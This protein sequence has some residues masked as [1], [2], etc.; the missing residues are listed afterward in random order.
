[1]EWMQQFTEWLKPYDEYTHWYVAVVFFVAGVFTVANA[2][3]NTWKE[4]NKIRRASYLISLPLFCV[5]TGLDTVLVEYFV[6]ASLL[7]V[8]VIL[9]VKSI[10]GAIVFSEIIRIWSKTGTTWS[11]KRHFIIFVVLM[12]VLLVLN[13]M[14]THT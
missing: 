4:N 7:V 13:L 12:G 8:N 10:V 2:G 9:I 5:F 3:E 11:D 6:S 14:G 1:M